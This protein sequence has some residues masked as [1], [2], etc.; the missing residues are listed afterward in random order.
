MQGA[1]PY[2]WGMSWLYLALL[3]PLLYAVVNLFD[4]NL[5][6]RVYKSP[7]LSTVFAGFFGALPLVA[8]VFKTMPSIGQAAIITAVAAGAFTTSYY[9][10]YFRALGVE[11]PSVVV[12]L[13]SLAPALLPVFAHLFLHERLSGLAILGFTI[14]LLAA[15]MMAVVD[16][17]N[18]KFSKALVP[19]VIAVILMDSGALLS[20]YAYE[21]AAFFPAYMYFCLGMGLGGVAF[22]SIRFKDNIQGLRDIKPIFWKVLPVFVAAE[23]VNLAA[24]LTLNLA[25][26]R[27]PVSL[28]KAIESIQPM[29][30]LLIA[31]VL[32][33]FA[34]RFFREA[35]EGGVAKKF[36]LMAVAVVGIVV[37]AVAANR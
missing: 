8:L 28:V 25:I 11:T 5:L 1:P 37:I 19:V 22:L 29:F 23:L 6:E 18:F 9:F 16:L 2:D 15:L 13:F 34:P 35:E 33:P 27:G 17:K 12:A 10:F 4:D 31:L 20:K 24:E 32:Y 36:L 21:H 30:V 26:G 3:A 14:V 7:Y